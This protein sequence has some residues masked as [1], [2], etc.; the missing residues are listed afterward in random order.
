MMR[1]ITKTAHGFRA[2][3]LIATLSVLVTS[4]VAFSQ[5]TPGP[6]PAP[7]PGPQPA[8]L[9]TA[10]NSPTYFVVDGVIQKQSDVVFY[11]TRN[12]P[13]DCDLLCDQI[14]DS[15]ACRQLCRIRCLEQAGIVC[16][17]PKKLPDPPAQPV[18]FETSTLGSTCAP[19]NSYHSTPCQTIVEDCKPVP[20]TGLLRRLLRRCP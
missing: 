20:R 3:C 14:F 11:N 16:T 5:E 19:P 8:P 2:I 18:L 9:P 1:R 6:Q 7:L 4:S 10:V 15:E 17:E 12:R 13:I